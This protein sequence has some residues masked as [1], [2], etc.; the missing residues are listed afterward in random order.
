MNNNDHYNLD[1]KG[2]KWLVSVWTDSTYPRNI[3]LKESE[4]FLIWKFVLLIFLNLEVV[5]NKFDLL[6]VLLKLDQIN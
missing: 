3:F 5:L 2:K 1:V 6:E 4:N